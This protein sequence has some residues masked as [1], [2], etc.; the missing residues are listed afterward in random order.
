MVENEPADIGADLN[1]PKKKP[2]RKVV[3]GVM[4]L[5]KRIVKQG[6]EPE[7]EEINERIVSTEEIMAILPHRGRMLLLNRVVIRPDR[8]IGEF[9]VTDEVC[10]GH[11]FEGRLVF[12]GSDFS[13]MAAQL[14]GVWAAQ[15]PDFEGKKAYARQYGGS[16]FQGLVSPGD[17]ILMEISAGHLRAEITIRPKFRKILVTGTDFSA[18]VGGQQIAKIFSV[19]LVA[20]EIEK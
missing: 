19:E 12:K 9:K 1:G 10:E 16:K 8:V 4:D 15:Y 18:M 13:D 2:P 14:L 3:Q 17:L 7:V 5:L 20:T 11:A 6:P